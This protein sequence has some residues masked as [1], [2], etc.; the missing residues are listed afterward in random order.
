MHLP[1]GDVAGG[2]EWGQG[3]VC[4]SAELARA[5]RVD[6]LW[7]ALSAP[8]LLCYEN[9]DYF[10]TWPG[11]LPFF[12]SSPPYPASSLLGCLPPASW[13]VLRKSKLISM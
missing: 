11:S 1:M 10:S 9:T 7:G 4:W 6:E 2:G 12:L 8:P 3:K 13:C 5:Q